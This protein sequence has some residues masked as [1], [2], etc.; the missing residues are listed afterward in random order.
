MC[1]YS[2]KQTYY[3]D[4]LFFVC[5]HKSLINKIL[6]V[7]AVRMATPTQNSK[8]YFIFHTY[9]H[10]LVHRLCVLCIRLF[11]CCIANEISFVILRCLLSYG[12]DKSWIRTIKCCSC[13]ALVLS[14]SS[15]NLLSDKI[16]HT[17]RIFTACDY[18]YAYK[19]A[20]LK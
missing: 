1:S 4:C 12:Q 5:F 7:V 13:K 2:L 10:I 15:Q 18:T 17:S 16:Y 8:C 9:T 3:Y 14:Y 19:I 6:T 20:I 11:V